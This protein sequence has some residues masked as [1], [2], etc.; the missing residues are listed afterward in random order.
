MLDMGT[1]IRDQ[2]LTMANHTAQGH[3][4]F[5]GPKRGPK[6]AIGM[7]LLDSLAIADIA[8][9]S[10]NIFEGTRIDQRDLEP[11][12]ELAL[13]HLEPGGTLLLCR[14]D[15]KAGDHDKLVALVDRSARKARIGLDELRPAPAGL[16]FPSRDGFPEGDPFNAVLVRTR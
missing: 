11:V 3:D 16:D 12:V 1:P 6:Q 9:P 7:E 2:H 10:G 15:R 5:R 13:A 4:L 8:F 14:N